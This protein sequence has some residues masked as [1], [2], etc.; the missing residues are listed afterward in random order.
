MARTKVNRSLALKAFVDKLM[1]NHP[2]ASTFTRA[3][4]EAVGKVQP[5]GFTEFASV[6]AGY[7]SS[8]RVGRGQYAIPSDWLAGKAPWT[9]VD[10]SVDV[11][12]PKATKATKATKTP[13]TKNTVETDVIETAVVTEPVMKKNPNPKKS[14]SKKELFEKAKAEIAKRKGSKKQEVAAGE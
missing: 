2:N 6:S 4:V 7:G 5:I 13:K 1:A 12:A 9:G 3:D 14:M 10:A 8:T 11:P